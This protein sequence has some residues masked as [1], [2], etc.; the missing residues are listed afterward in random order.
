[1]VNPMP[2]DSYIDFLIFCFMR[3]LGEVT[4]QTTT[5]SFRDYF[6][7]DERKSRLEGEFEV[8]KLE[9]PLDIWFDPEQL[10]ILH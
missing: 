3:W 5:E 6:E 8:A 9:V 7:N 2:D 10:K 4:E 1:M